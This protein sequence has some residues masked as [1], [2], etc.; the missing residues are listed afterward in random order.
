MRCEIKI[1]STLGLM[2]LLKERIPLFEPQSAAM[3]VTGFVPTSQMMDRLKNGETA[4]V[5]ILTA[6]GIDDLILAETILAS[7][8]T[9]LARSSVG[10]AVR[11][12]A[13]QPDI[14]IVPAFNQALLDT[15]SICY[16]RTGASGIFFAGLI[17]R[18]EIAPEVNA[19]ATI[20]PTGLTAEPVARGE[21]AMAVQQISELMAVPGV[22]I[23]GRLP[24]AIEDQNHA[25]WPTAE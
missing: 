22:D 11:A 25:N 6:A 9:D 2:G 1:L 10:I 7:S 12:H 13:D 15:P 17:E 5:A 4:D 24:A 3:I 21:A 18:L 23:V 19:K 20:L 8:R 14:S 16:S